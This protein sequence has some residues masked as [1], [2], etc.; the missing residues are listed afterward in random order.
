M[1]YNYALSFGEPTKLDSDF[2]RPKGIAVP[3][4][5]VEKPEDTNMYDYFA[6]I[7]V[8]YFGDDEE[9]GKSIL[10]ES[11]SISTPPESYLDD[12]LELLK[13]VDTSSDEQLKQVLEESSTLGESPNTLEDIYTR[14]DTD[15]VTLESQ[16]AVDSKGETLEIGQTEPIGLM[17]R[18]SGETQVDKTEL[19]SMAEKAAPTEEVDVDS[20]II[21]SAFLNSIGITGSLTEEGVQ[22]EVKK[23][24]KEQ[25]LTD[26]EI[27]AIVDKSLASVPDA[28]EVQLT[29][30]KEYA[31]DM[32]ALSA[33]K[34]VPKL[35]KIKEFAKDTFNNP[36]KA[37]AFVATVEAESAAGLVESADYIRSA[38]I[39]AAN[40]GKFKDRRKKL[41]ENIWN[42]SSNTYLDDEG[43]L[44]LNEQGQE[45][46]FNV[47]YADQY[48]SEKYKL[49][50]TEPGDGWKYRGRGLIQISGKRNYKLLGESL[51]VD[52]VS[53]P[54]L[55]E[56]DKDIM[57]RAT[58]QYLKDNGFIFAD[59]TKNK[60]ASIIGHA[61]NENKDEANNRWASTQKFYKEMY[62]EDMPT[63]S[64]SV[65]SS[66]NTSPRPRLKPAGTMERP[67]L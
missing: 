55:L 45:K 9:K 19:P 33:D 65:T 28:D 66:L 25:G 2:K 5:K 22:K 37:A 32:F 23:V 38:S 34:V 13:S 7:I 16:P 30:G 18:P 6:D 14:M 47:L 26:E 1:E 17:S 54:E 10:T 43:V 58:L 24:L 67:P 3:P 35:D 4:K 56:T 61:D 42:D 29:D 59:L 64:R 63:S 21:S 49:G 8:G 52:L 12:T 60:L 41:V 44:R 31:T 48:R 20:D 46:F 51:G 27:N 50:N 11:P 53:N 62:N 15:P 57:I 36:V 40:K 39:K